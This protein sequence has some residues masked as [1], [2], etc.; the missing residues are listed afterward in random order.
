M[1]E[2]YATKKGIPEMLGPRTASLQANHIM[3][4]R[5][6]TDSLGDRIDVY[7]DIDSRKLSFKKGNTLKMQKVS[8][9]DSTRI[10]AFMGIRKAFGIKHMGH[11]Q[12]TWNEFENMWEIVIPPEN[13]HSTEKD[14]S[15]NESRGAWDASKPEPEP[16]PPKKKAF[17]SW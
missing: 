14:A 6:L 17:S 2:K 11:L 3:F 5:I 12:A 15:W 10:I 16:E 4:G 9:R 13:S 1:R 7:Y 8:S